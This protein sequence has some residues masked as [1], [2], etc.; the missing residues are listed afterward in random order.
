[1]GYTIF[2]SDTFKIDT[3]DFTAYCYNQPTETSYYEKRVLLLSNPLI[4]RP[5]IRLLS[6]ER[7]CL[8]LFI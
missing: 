5:N 1:M 4:Y 7:K 3:S 8:K 6:L 2:Q